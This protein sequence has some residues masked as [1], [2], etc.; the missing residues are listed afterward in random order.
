[1]AIIAGGAH[2]VQPR[3][4]STMAAWSIQ[5]A[6]NGGATVQG[7]A[8]I[9]DKENV[10]QSRGQHKVDMYVKNILDLMVQRPEEIVHGTHYDGVISRN[11]RGNPIM[12]QHNRQIKITPQGAFVLFGCLVNDANRVRL[13]N[14]VFV[15]MQK[16]AEV[17]AR[18]KTRFD[19]YT[20][21]LQ[22]HRQGRKD[23]YSRLRGVYCDSMGVDP[24]AADCSMLSVNKRMLKTCFFGEPPTKAMR[25]AGLLGKT[26]KAGNVSQQFSP[27]G[28]AIE[29]ARFYMQAAAIQVRAAEFDAA[30]DAQSKKRVMKSV[31]DVCYDTFESNGWG[32]I[33]GASYVENTRAYFN[34]API[35]KRQRI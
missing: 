14:D 9:V 12:N 25:D 18:M 33:P 17:C 15:G 21:Q 10:Y 8:E 22:S 31:E 11:S 27:F 3:R 4:T 2:A 19:E 24:R 20:E 16:A 28:H 5:C 23:G 13:L 29:N 34:K 35:S 7:T 6:Q 26:E 30:P 32:R 1:M